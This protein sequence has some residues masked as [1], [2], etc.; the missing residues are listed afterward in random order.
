MTKPKVGRI[1]G[2]VKAF[3]SQIR[4]H[5]KNELTIEYHDLTLKYATRS[6]IAKRWF[7]PRY[8]S[9][10]RVHEPPIAAL[11]RAELD[12]ESTFFDVGANLGF[13]T[14]LAA[15]ICTASNGSV[16]AFELDPTL[17]PLVEGS[18][19]LNDQCGAVQLNCVAC[20]GETGQFHTFRAAQ[21]NNPSTNQIVPDGT[22]GRGV[23]AQAMTVTL[24]HYRKHTGTS[25]DLIKMDI[26]GAETLAIPGMLD[27]VEKVR[28]TLILEVHPEDVRRLGGTPATLVNQ[29][30]EAGDYST[31]SHV[32]S[33]RQEVEHPDEALEPLDMSMFEGDRPV[34]VLLSP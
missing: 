22:D 33:H 7:Y 25:P 23:S 13:F 4:A 18:L 26:E 14:V 17:I 31:V 3:S 30:R 21:K 2:R 11:I 1:V 10:K 27:L 19:Q 6:P 28:P 16:H 5:F 20:A 32:D 12:P 24:D 8:I 34:V 29:L 15:N 9:G